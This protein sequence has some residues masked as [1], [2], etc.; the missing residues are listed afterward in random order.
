MEVNY[1]AILV[2]TIAAAVLGMVWYSPALF[3]KA[4]MKLVGMSQK[5]LEAAKKQGM[6]KNMAI[7][8]VA[9]F[10]MAWVFFHFAAG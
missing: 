8:F 4:W 3:G 5:D 9:T 2:A 10:V 6:A 1:L 7:N